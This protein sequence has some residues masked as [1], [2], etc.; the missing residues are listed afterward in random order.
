MPWAIKW[1]YTSPLDG[2]RKYLA[3]GARIARPDAF[4]GYTIMVFATRAQ[5]R[6][7]I[8][9]EYGYLA[10]RPDLRLPPYCWKMPKAVRVTVKVSEM[11]RKER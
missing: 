3:G 6:R 11:G 2:R 9:D 5:A 1:D 7:F 4:S 8:A 10:S